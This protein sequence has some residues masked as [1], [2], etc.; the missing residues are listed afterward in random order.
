MG[1]DEEVGLEIKTV[2]HKDKEAQAKA[3]AA[4]TEPPTEAP[5]KAAK[6]NSAALASNLSSLASA[7]M[8]A[9]VCER[10]FMEHQLAAC[11][12]TF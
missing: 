2:A 8:L 1:E 12:F 4:A 10:A 9:Q 11:H 7:S 3:Q 6:S 5:E